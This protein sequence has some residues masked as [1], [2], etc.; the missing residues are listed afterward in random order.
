MSATPWFLLSCI[1]WSDLTSGGLWTDLD[2][3]TLGF[4]KM[5]N[6]WLKITLDWWEAEEIPLH[7]VHIGGIFHNRS[8]GNPVYLADLSFTDFQPR[9][10]KDYKQ[11]PTWF[12][13][14]KKWPTEFKCILQSAG[15]KMAT[16]KH[17]N[18]EA[19][20]FSYEGGRDVS[21]TLLLNVH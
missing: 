20:G 2:V 16:I 19:I 1:C 13:T 15:R 5:P 18:M 17:E 3:W 21:V 6:S 8:C 4:S 7:F 10:L 12:S 11:S 14:I 9:I